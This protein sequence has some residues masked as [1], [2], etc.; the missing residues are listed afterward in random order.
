M[1][2][3]KGGNLPTAALAAE[4]HHEVAEAAVTVAVL[5]SDLRHRAA[6][7]EDSTQGLIT[8]LE[9]LGRLAEEVFAQDVI[10]GWT[11]GSVIAL[12]R[13]LPRIDMFSAGTVGKEKSRGLELKRAILRAGEAKSRQEA[14]A[15]AWRKKL[16]QPDGGRQNAMTNGGPKTQNSCGFLTHDHKNCH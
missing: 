6:L 4:P 16:S 12:M 7:A 5:L 1:V 15:D 11:S 3:R 10:H 8:A 2:W 13:S 9:T 14:N